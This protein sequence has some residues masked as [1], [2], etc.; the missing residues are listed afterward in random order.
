VNAE[1]DARLFRNCAHQAYWGAEAALVAAIGM[2][3]EDVFVEAQTPTPVQQGLQAVGQGQPVG[4]VVLGLEDDEKAVFAED[5]APFQLG[6]F[7]AP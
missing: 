7:V 2:T 6:R 3:G 4:L 1:F 5:A